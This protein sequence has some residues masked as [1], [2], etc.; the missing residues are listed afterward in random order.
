MAQTVVAS[1]QARMGSS[2]LPG[3]VLKDICGRPMIQWQIERLR[4]SRLIDQVIVAT[5]YS[6]LDDEIVAFCKDFGVECF[7]GSEHDVLGRVAGLV[8]TYEAD[9]HVECFGDSPMID[10][11]LVDE[12]LGYFFKHANEF[13]VVTNA[14]ETSYP[15]GLDFW[16]YRGSCLQEI[17]EILGESD[18]LREHA[19]YNLTR[20]P[21]K[22]RIKSLQAPPR[23][24][25]GRY[26]MEV[27][28]A[29]DLEVVREVFSFFQKNGPEV[30][31]ISHLVS[32]MDENQDLAKRN[33]HVERRWKLL[34][35]D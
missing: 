19:G 35:D 7:R 6:D 9:V 8:S 5:S 13:D 22:F 23:F 28:T 1:I 27:D 31:G 17:D 24:A 12:F 16:V 25:G 3:K 11:Q 14:I 26:Y 30:F 21:N 4:A 20:F 34:R 33:H 32:F 15:P 18:Q 2:R 29:I 10:P